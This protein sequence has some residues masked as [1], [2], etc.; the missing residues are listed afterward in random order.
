MAK[1]KSQRDDLREHMRRNIEIAKM[2]LAPD[3][4]GKFNDFERGLLASHI[5]YEYTDANAE[6]ALAGD[7]V[8]LL[9]L[10]KGEQVIS[11]MT[12]LS[13][14][15]KAH[16]QSQAAET[17]RASRATSPERIALESAVIELHGNKKCER[18]SK[19]AAAIL[20]AV[21]RRLA[22]GGFGPVKVDAIRRC[23]EKLPRSFRPQ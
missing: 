10:L 17:A 5:E 19:E 13:E 15:H 16:T 2:C 3:W 12:G 23:L 20:S 7:R 21:N 22:D 14:T 9:R 8:A 11:V 6:A 18:S 4:S 1:K